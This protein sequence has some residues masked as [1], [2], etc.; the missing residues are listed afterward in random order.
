MLNWRNWIESKYNED[1]DQDQDDERDDVDGDDD[2][3]RVDHD[4]HRKWGNGS[5]SAAVG[6]WVSGE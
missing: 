4:D 2:D 3:D 6:E 1:E 5:V